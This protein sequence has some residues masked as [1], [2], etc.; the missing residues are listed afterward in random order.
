MIG[1]EVCK[2]TL[3]VQTLDE[4]N[5]ALHQKWNLAVT[6]A[7]IRRL[8]TDMGRRLRRLSVSMEDTPSINCLAYNDQP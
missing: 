2:R 4:L 6:S 1:H 5:N 3:S 8:L 7:T